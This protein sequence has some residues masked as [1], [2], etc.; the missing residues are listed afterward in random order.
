MIREL[1]QRWGLGRSWDPGRH[2]KESGTR[3]LWYDQVTATNLNPPK[4]G[5]LKLCSIMLSCRFMVFFN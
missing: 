4:K 3:R 5:L 2:I 1:W